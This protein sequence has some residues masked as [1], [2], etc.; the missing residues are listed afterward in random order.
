[1]IQSRKQQD[2]ANLVDL[3]T[4]MT[5]YDKLV[6]QKVY[7]VVPEHRPVTRQPYDELYLKQKAAR[8]Y[9]S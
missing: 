9:W 6:L 5:D 4:P 2:I 8:D 3:V 1:M 7:G